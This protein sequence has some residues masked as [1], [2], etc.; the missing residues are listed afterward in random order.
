M[1][2][3][4]SID[5][6][7]AIL[8]TGAGLAAALTS[9]AEN[10]DPKLVAKKPGEE[11]RGLKI[12][13]ASYSMK[14]SPVDD[15]IACCRRVGIRYVA[16]KDVH[17]KLTSTTEERTAMRKKFSDSGVEI[18]GC[19]VIYLKNDEDVIRRAFEYA[20]D[21][22]AGTAVIGCNR[23]TVPAVSKVIRDFDLRAAI[24]NHGPQ[25]KLGANSPIEV[26]EWLKDA[27]KKIGF[28]MDVGHTFRCGVDPAAI[29]AKYASRLYDIHNKD[30]NEATVN[31]KGVPLGRGVVDVAGLLK[32]LVKTKYAH[33]VALE[34]EVGKVD[35]VP[36]IVESIAYTRGV[37][38]S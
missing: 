25:D 6:R 5:R 31:A 21:I 16:L 1:N 29:A 34:Y 17:L 18:I 23:E 19:G 11:F 38:A 20:R 3:T 13:L 8:M 24:H 4:N 12:G 30:L 15:V 22:G 28:C 33:H 14:S 7:R 27:D 9:R 36:G 37:L 10:R 26:M 35:P 2:L 32:T